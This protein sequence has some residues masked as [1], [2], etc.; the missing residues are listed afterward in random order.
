MSEIDWNQFR[1]DF[2]AEWQQNS[3][4]AEE[5]QVEEQVNEPVTEEVDNSADT[6]EP[7]EQPEQVQE[8]EVPSSEEQPETE[9]L[10]DNLGSDSD[11]S[12]SEPVEDAPQ[13]PGEAPRQKPKQTPEENKAFAEM[14]H[15]LKE[16][17]RYKEVI[18][19]IAAQQGVPAD[20]LIQRFQD[21]QERQ[22]AEQQGLSLEQYRE[23]QQT[24][25][26]LQQLETELRQKEYVESIKSVQVKYGIKSE[27]DPKIK[28]TFEYIREKRMYDPNTFIPVVPFEDVFKIAN[29]EALV[30]EAAKQ[31]K[32][33]HL[34][35]KK[36][37]QQQAAPVA[38]TGG[39]VEVKP[40]DF[41]SMSSEEFQEF[42]KQRGV[43]LDY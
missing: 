13:L 33:E 5:A 14:R 27:D 22:M 37:R 29:H 32:Q 1:A 19:K 41:M 9:T 15:R 36:Q 24:K 35:A 40:K 6:E 42:L 3:Q 31:A 25:Q 43:S 26:R 28:R 16:M 11:E 8:E 17:E 34:K 18:E 10:I 7:S 39:A 20:F 4:P 38:H 30:Q 23:F 12:D 21:E 2:E